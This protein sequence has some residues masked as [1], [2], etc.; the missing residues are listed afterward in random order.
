MIEPKRRESCWHEAGHAV[1]SHLRSRWC[2]GAWLLDGGNIPPE[3]GKLAP[4]H[5][6]LLRGADGFALTTT[7]KGRDLDAADAINHGIV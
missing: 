6:R 4:E 7:R 5:E 3:L 1:A 2:G